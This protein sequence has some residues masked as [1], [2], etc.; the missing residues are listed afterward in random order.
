MSASPLLALVV[1]TPVVA[2]VDLDLPVHQLTTT[3]LDQLLATAFTLK[4]TLPPARLT[5]HSHLC[6]VS[7]TWMC[8]VAFTSRYDIEHNLDVAFIMRF[9]QARYC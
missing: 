8:F 9:N 1:V 2:T 3:S 6:G 4:A 5:R 7:K